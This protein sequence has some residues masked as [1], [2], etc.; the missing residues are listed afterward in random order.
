MELFIHTAEIAGVFVGF[1]ALIAIRSGGASGPV[2]VS[3]MRAVVWMGTMTVVACLA[4]VTLSRYG[5][6]EHHVWAV[7]SALV[8]VGYWG[9]AVFSQLTPELRAARATF[10]RMYRVTEAV[11]SIVFIGLPMVLA[12]GA[13]MFGLA[14]HLEPA[15]YFT[16]VVLILLGTAQ[17]LLTLVYLQRR[18]D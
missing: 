13:I 12:L 10:S 2:E 7:S 8:L 11:V 9:M 14:P 4:P 17:T 18:V 15:L 6:A 16:A 5:L 1:G 3:Y